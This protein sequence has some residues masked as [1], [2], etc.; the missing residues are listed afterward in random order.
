MIRGHKSDLVGDEFFPQRGPFIRRADWRVLLETGAEF[1]HLTLF[2]GK[3]LYTGFGA[4]PHAVFTV[5]S[6]MIEAARERAVHDVATHAGHPSNFE[7]RDIGD[8]LGD[9]RAARTVAFRCISPLAIEALGQT[10]NDRRIFVVES[11]RKPGFSNYRK[12]LK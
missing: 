4:R 11:D 10:L 5:P 9:R 1:K 8:Q 6:D 12:N 7:D 3:V 2:K